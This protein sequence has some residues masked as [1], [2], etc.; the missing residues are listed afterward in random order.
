LLRE[1]AEEPGIGLCQQA[2]AWAAGRAGV[3]VSLELGALGRV[4]GVAQDQLFGQVG[5]FAGA[6]F[7]GMGERNHG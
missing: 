4:E 1:P 5:A 2:P 6:S 7:A 3:G